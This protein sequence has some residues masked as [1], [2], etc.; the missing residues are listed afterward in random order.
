M[1]P[2]VLG[3]ICKRLGLNATLLNFDID[4]T[5]PGHF[6]D[7]SKEENLKELK[8]KILETDADIG[9]AFDGDA[10]RLTVV[11]EKGE[12]VGADF[13]V[14]LFYKAKSGW[15]KK[16]KV[17][18]DLRFSRSV[19]ALFGK[20]GFPSRTGYVFVRKTMKDAGA[21]F[22]GE[23]AGHFDFKEMNYA[24]SA[25]LAML[26]MAGIVAKGTR[27]LSELINPFLKYFNSG[28]INIDLPITNQYEYT[29]LQIK[30]LE[31]LKNKYRDGKQSFLDGITVDYKD[32]WFNVRPSN[33]EPIMRLVVEAN[34]GELME[35]KT[36]E[37]KAI[38]S[39]P[40]F[41]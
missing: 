35:N 21:D 7:I 3:D 24:E 11:D 22:G 23:L 40:S 19:K 4:G 20:N 39:S 30:T 12:K 18:Y 2:V 33:T 37:L 14:G 6:P 41:P 5:F 31:M 28:E 8:N 27:P 38:I 17:A 1:A 29:N 34:T 25:I 15:F 10:D 26:K 16:P 13:V 32:W 9:F 36:L